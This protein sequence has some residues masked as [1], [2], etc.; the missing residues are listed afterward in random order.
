M[1]IPRDKLFHAVAGLVIGL[2]GG[3]AGGLLA[4][5]LPGLAAGTCL[6]VLAGVAK[7]VYDHNRG[8]TVE[9]ADALVTAGA[10]LVGALVGAWWLTL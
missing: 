3:A 10:G 9:A 5:F 7:E 2:I 8:G 6:A 4:G 1:S